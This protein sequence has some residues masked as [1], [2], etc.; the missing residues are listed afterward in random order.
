MQ[1][2]QCCNRA[3]SRSPIWRV[4]S[5]AGVRDSPFAVFPKLRLFSTQVDHAACQFLNRLPVLWWCAAKCSACRFSSPGGQPSTTE[6]LSVPVPNGIGCQSSGI[7]ISR[8]SCARGLFIG[9]MGGGVRLF[10]LGG[11]ERGGVAVTVS[12]MSRDCPVTVAARWRRLRSRSIARLCSISSSRVSISRNAIS[13]ASIGAPAS[14]IAAISSDAFN[15]ALPVSSVQSHNSEE[16][17][18][19]LGCGRPCWNCRTGS[20]W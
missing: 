10:S 1:A 7:E 20:T 16:S 8:P 17:I 5:R 14:I 12:G 2:P 9:G 6:R 4:L 11:R 15:L 18:H 19:R 3:A 13:A